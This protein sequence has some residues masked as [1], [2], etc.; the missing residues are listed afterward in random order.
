MELD[1]KTRIA[2][3]R[4]R[5]VSWRPTV[6]ELSHD[7]RDIRIN[8]EG[9]FRRFPGLSRTLFLSA[10]FVLSLGLGLGLK[11]FSEEYLAIGHGDY[12]LIPADR[13]YALNELRERALER[14][15]V[16]PVSEQRS[17][18]ACSVLTDLDEAL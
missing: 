2:R 13:L 9:A 3:L 15:A 12:R 14:G 1:L 17:Y 18:P 10:L 6:D 16:L 4:E 11:S 5:L 8:F 7:Y